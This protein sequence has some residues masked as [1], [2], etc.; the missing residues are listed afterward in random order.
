MRL[1]SDRDARDAD[2]AAMMEQCR[3]ILTGPEELCDP[4]RGF[5]ATSSGLEISVSVEPLWTTLLCR[6]R[7]EYRMAQV[8]TGDLAGFAGAVRALLHTGTT[9]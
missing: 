2:V 8:K 7:S 9:H 1:H 6:E 3:T 4:G 5:C